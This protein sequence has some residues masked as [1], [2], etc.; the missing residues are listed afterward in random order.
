MEKIFKVW[1]AVIIS[2]III[3]FILAPFLT[4]QASFRIVFG[5]LFVLFI[6]GY[7]ITYIFFPESTKD[8]KIDSIERITLSFALSIAI[9]PLI[10]FYLNRIGVKITLLNSVLI[11][12]AIIVASLIIIYFKQKK[13]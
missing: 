9:V 12:I 2:L 13:K 4:I 7:F 10:I 3:S 8:H 6:P 5:S 1:L 11:I